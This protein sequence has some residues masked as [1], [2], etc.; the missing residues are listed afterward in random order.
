VGSRCEWRALREVDLMGEK[1]GTQDGTVLTALVLATSAAKA[2]DISAASTH[3]NAVAHFI[4][5]LWEQRSGAVEG[6]GRREMSGTLYGLQI[7]ITV[8]QLEN[9]I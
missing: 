3:T 6:G 5:S 1:N 7:A 2:D 4:G 8:A 9:M